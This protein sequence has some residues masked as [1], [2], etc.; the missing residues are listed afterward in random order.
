MPDVCMGELGHLHTVA[1]QVT[2][3]ASERSIS[4]E[5]SDPRGGT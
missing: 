3:C 1:R 2:S 4:S 5:Y